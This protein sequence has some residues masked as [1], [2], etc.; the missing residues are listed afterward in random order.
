MGRK[1]KVDH[2][3]F[4]AAYGGWIELGDNVSVNCYAVLHGNGGLKIGDGVR[5]AAHAVLVSANHRFGRMDVPIYQQGMD[6]KGVT[7]GDDVWI[8]ANV[9]VLDGSIIGK[10]CV[11][12]AGA[13]V[14]GTLEPYGVYGGVPVRKLRQR[15]DVV[16]GDQRN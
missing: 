1:C 15:Q 2:G 16:T 7:I 11:I 6:R 14:R 3:A 13:V 10:G 12:A 8:G 9:V 5:I 4:L